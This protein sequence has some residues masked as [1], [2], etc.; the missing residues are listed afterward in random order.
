M[1]SAEEELLQSCILCSIT[2]EKDPSNTVKMPQKFVLFFLPLF[3]AYLLSG[4][5]LFTMM[6]Y[7]S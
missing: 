6:P 4:C 7:I 2:K 1:Q 3:V 5:D